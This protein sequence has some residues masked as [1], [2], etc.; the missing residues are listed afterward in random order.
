MK[1]KAAS[2]AAPRA[3]ESLKRSVCE[4]NLELVR[5]GLVV[6][7]WGNVSGVDREVRPREF[8]AQYKVA[9][10]EMACCVVLGY[11]ALDTRGN[12]L[13]TA[14][15][16][17]KGHFRSLRLVTSDWHMRRSA[18]ELDE[19]LPHVRL[20]E[21]AVPSEPSLKTLFLEYHKLLASWLGRL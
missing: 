21:D 10:A 13:E 20:V 2:R 7:T 18:G 11:T 4:A 16:V 14:D 12:A 15:W 5:K 8:V 9:Q 3:V 6:E 19:V 17:N 1:R